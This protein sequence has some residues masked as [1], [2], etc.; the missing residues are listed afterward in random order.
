MGRRG[1]LPTCDLCY[2]C[3][4]RSSPKVTGYLHPGMNQ[5]LASNAPKLE[6]SHHAPG[7]FHPPQ[8]PFGTHVRFVRLRTLAEAQGVPGPNRSRPAHTG[9]SIRA[10]C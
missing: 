9:I 4:P 5:W 10:E 1:K 7:V 2:R 6:T 8:G 3:K